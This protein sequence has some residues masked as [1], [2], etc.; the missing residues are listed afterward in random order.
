MRAKLNC[1]DV[2]TASSTTT[3]PRAPALDGLFRA[4]QA[5]TVPE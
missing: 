3:L 2:E 1:P 5:L 4:I